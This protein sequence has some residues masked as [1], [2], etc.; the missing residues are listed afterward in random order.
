MAGAPPHQTQ[1]MDLLDN[2]GKKKRNEG[3]THQPDDGGIERGK[4][5]ALLLAGMP[6]PET[7]CPK[8]VQKT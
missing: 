6:A 4:T 8:M 2:N 5:A 3:R 7:Q 1:G